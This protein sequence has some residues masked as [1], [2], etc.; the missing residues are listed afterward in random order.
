MDA[1]S[2]LDCPVCH[3]L[4]GNQP[5]NAAGWCEA[6]KKTRRKRGSRTSAIADKAAALYFRLGFT[7]ALPS[8]HADK[9]PPS[10]G[11][12]RN[13]AMRIPARFSSPLPGWSDSALARS[14]ILMRRKVVICTAFL[15]RLPRSRPQERVDSGSLRVRYDCSL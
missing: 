5:P 6:R 8:W 7:S 11:P 2:V 9:D 14:F 15:A 13:M 12:G 1:V 3:S 4:A 10:L